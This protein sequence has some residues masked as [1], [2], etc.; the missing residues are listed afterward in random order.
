MLLTSTAGKYIGRYW[1]LNL[2]LPHKNFLMCFLVGGLNFDNL[3]TT[4]HT[5]M[6]QLGLNI[7]IR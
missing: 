5:G 6:M 4:D 1:L 2:R 3:S 7:V